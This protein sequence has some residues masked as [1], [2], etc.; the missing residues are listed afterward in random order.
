MVERLM[1]FPTINADVCW[2][3]PSGYIED[4]LAA[5][6]LQVSDETI[7]ALR[8]ALPHLFDSLRRAIMKGEPNVWK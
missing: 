6:T 7:P 8:M 2:G 1:S 3:H 5:E 4:E